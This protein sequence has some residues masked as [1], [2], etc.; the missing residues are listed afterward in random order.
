MPDTIKSGLNSIFQDQY[1]YLY[2]RFWQFFTYVFGGFIL[3]DIKDKEYE[4]LSNRTGIPISEIPRAFDACNKLFPRHDGW[5]F[6]FP[7]SEIEWHNFFPISFSGIGAN[8]RRMI[9]SSDG[10]YESLEKKLTGQMTMNDLT[11]WNNLSYKILKN[12]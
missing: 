9:Y 6:K 8:Y 2:P 7:T 10:T 3:T 11:K 1:F 4:V 5:F 12:W